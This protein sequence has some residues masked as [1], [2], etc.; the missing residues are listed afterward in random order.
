MKR[1]SVLMGVWLLA[2]L[3]C[4]ASV[5][6]QTRAWLDRD[7]IGEGDVVTL[8]IETDQAGAAP[9][10]APLQADFS[11]GGRTSGRQTR[12]VNGSISNTALFGVV[13]TPRRSGVLQVPALRVGTVQT[14]PLQLVVDPAPVASGGDA[15]AFVETEVDD[16]Q[17]YVQQSVG[18][19]VRLYFATQLASGEL[20]LATPA[21]ASLQRVGQDRTS[22]RDVGGRRY[23]VVERRFLLIP[24]RS[25]P[26]RLEGARFSGRGAGGLFDD[27]LGRGG[28][29]LSARSPDQTL[30]VR[31]V[32]DAAP[33]P[34]LPLKDLRLRYTAA[35]QS[36]RVGEALTLEVEATAVG[37]TRAQFPDLPLPAA[38]D[39]AQVFAEPAQYDES[40]DGA[41]P[42]LK[43]TRRYSIVPQRPGTLV[44]PGI[45][46]R[47]WDVGAAEARTATLPELSLA[48]APG[49]A[50]PAPVPAASAASAAAPATQVDRAIA[51]P[52]AGHLPQRL[53]PLLAA[54]F[55]L[56]WLATL[57]W[58]LTRRPSASP[59]AASVAEAAPGMATHSL[60][61][62]RRALDSGDLDDVE[63]A[64]RGMAR[65]P[66]ADL[67][68]LAA[69]LGSAVQREALEALRRA[70]W[71]G[72][73]G[74]V[75]R[76]ALRTAFA[77]GP[78]WRGQAREP[79][80]PLPPLYPGRGSG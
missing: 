65:P 11:L 69:R 37:A 68:A 20:D 14:R 10:Y 79:A 61:D 8:N 4:V 43:L 39:A 73:S 72:G 75:A 59:R 47:W 35:P 53:W 64:L 32:P 45:G 26:L 5:Q 74:P 77:N 27:F 3:A 46:L 22:A 31:A 71:A 34:W 2:W 40:F 62:L 56:L 38:G 63:Q 18:V 78:E 29:T 13:L 6:A 54:G 76:A 30:Q 67:D 60:A 66:V 12:M 25:G 52:G 24:E 19:V 41:G 28:G 23:N 57:V 55:A 51:L 9:D 80:A 16:P 36:A 58:A 21:S 42:R 48:V 33:Q 15:P 70:R 44:L 17:P 49:S 50:V 7:R 1:R